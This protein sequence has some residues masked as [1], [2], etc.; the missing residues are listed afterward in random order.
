MLE[1]EIERHHVAKVTR[2]GGIAY[3]FVSPGRV[4]VPDRIDVFGAH[5]GA[6]I[7]RKHIES[8][9][10]PTTDMGWVALMREAL[11]ASI[12]FTEL[13]APGKKPN[14][15]QLREHERLR[16]LGFRVDV[17]DGKL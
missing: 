8:Q 2:T 9:G 16:L 4:G 6:G 11:A 1:R 12:R 15:S 13:K 7:L 14:A 5:R 17:V 3:K 10:V